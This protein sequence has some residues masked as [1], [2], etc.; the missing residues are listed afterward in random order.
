[1]IDCLLRKRLKSQDWLQNLTP[2]ALTSFQSN[3]N[4]ESC[5]MAGGRIA[6]QRRQNHFILLFKNGN[7]SYTLMT[8]VFVLSIRQEREM[9][10]EMSLDSARSRRSLSFK[11]RRIVQ[12]FWTN[13]HRIFDLISFISCI[14]SPCVSLCRD[15]VKALM[16]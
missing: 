9:S 11:L 10:V 15:D 6:V 5:E 8:V 12:L 4:L 16:H 3:Q 2:G 7:N 13:L 14:A 1:M